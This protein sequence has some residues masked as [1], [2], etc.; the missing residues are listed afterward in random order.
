MSDTESED[1]AIEIGKQ[2]YQRLHAII[3]DIN[4]QPFTRT[5]EWYD[6]HNHILQSYNDHFNG[7][8]NIHP[9]YESTEFRTNCTL[10]DTLMEKLLKEYDSYR[11][12]SLYDYNRFNQTFVWVADYVFNTDDDDEEFSDMFGSL[13]ILSRETN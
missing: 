12:F 13:D 11:W 8:S 6:E 1:E 3:E 4:S 5:E 2:R 7:F 10:L 9:E